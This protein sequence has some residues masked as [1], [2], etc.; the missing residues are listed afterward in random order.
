MR[1]RRFGKRSKT[2]GLS[3]REAA[4]VF[5]ITRATAAKWLKHDDA[6]DRSCRAH[7]LHTNLSE[8]QEAIVISLHQTLYLSTLPR[9]TSTLT[10]HCQDWPGCSSAKVWP[11]WKT[12]FP[13]LKARSFKPRK[14]L[15]I[16]RLALPT[17]ISSISRRC[18]TRLP[19]A[20]C[21]WLSIE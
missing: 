7:K 10:C 1:G 16:N 11:V 6:Q 19:A 17:S 18:Q 9:N 12:S 8:G 13:L 14:P 15:R 4:K 2:L 3:D 5:N 20:I 21:S